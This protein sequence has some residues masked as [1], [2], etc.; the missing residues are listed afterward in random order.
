M[1]K[2]NPLISLLLPVF[3]GPFGQLYSSVV[4][5]AVFLSI[6]ILV[7][8]LYGILLIWF[9]IPIYV[10]YISFFLV[11][12]LE[13]HWTQNFVTEYN[14]RIDEKAPPLTQMQ[15]LSEGFRDSYGL[16]Q[17]ILISL[18]FTCCI[19]ALL[20]LT[21]VLRNENITGQTI[22]FNFSFW[23]FFV[24]STLRK[25]NLETDRQLS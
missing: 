23:T 8:I 18:F 2:K 24:F 6:Y 3:L 13:L 1:Q 14:N 4:G 5:F 25:R 20:F 10:F 7:A 17:N 19:Q 11:L 12:C 9:Y 22:I 15:A 16:L 21:K